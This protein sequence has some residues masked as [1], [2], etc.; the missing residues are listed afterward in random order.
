MHGSEGAQAGV[1]APAD[2]LH[3][4]GIGLLGI[5]EVPEPGLLGEGIGVEPIQQLQIHAEAPVGVLGGVDMEIGEAGQNQMAGIIQQGKGRIGLWYGIKDTGA[6]SVHAEQIAVGDGAE[7]VGVDTI[8]E[9]ALQEKRGSVHG[10]AP[11]SLK[12]DFH[13]FT[14]AGRGP[15]SG[16]LIARLFAAAGRDTQPILGLYKSLETK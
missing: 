10:R 4:A 5:G 7:G 16:K 3:K 6:A 13:L 9:I 15:G 2:I 14:A 12:C 8:T 11:L 1:G